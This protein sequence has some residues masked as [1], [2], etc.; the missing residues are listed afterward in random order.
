MQEFKNQSAPQDTLNLKEIIA[1][2]SSQLAS[3]KKQIAELTA[4]R[5]RAADLFDKNELY[6][7]Y[8]KLIEE[9]DELIK[10]LVGR[11]Q[12]AQSLQMLDVSAPNSTIMR[13][14]P[15]PEENVPVKGNNPSY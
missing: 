1:R 5:Y 14:Q 3:Q 9:R 4:Q 12:Q 10:N 15:T 6:Q 13:A 11:L 2:Q 8:Q 7:T